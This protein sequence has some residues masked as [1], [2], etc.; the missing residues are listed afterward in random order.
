M[1]HF[2]YYVFSLEELQFATYVPLKA[3]FTS[4]FFMSMFLLKQVLHLCNS[5]QNHVRHC[6]ISM[7]VQK[8]FLPDDEYLR[9]VTSGRGYEPLPYSG[10]YRNPQVKCN[11][12]AYYG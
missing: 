6:A 2:F 12:V 8:A 10:V 7:Y 9:V 1:Q 4:S 11:N 3:L 5:P